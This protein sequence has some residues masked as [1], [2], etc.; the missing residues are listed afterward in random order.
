MNEL[1]KRTVFGLLYVIVIVGSI[2]LGVWAFAI[3]MLV[4]AFIGSME[5]GKLMSTEEHHSIK[6]PVAI[7]T[8]VTFAAFF[9]LAVHKEVR[10]AAVMVPFIPFIVALFVKKYSF[11]EIFLGCWVSLI[12]VFFPCVII[13][14]AATEWE[15]GLIA[16][17]GM[18]W[19][20]D[21]FAYLTGKW[22]GKH[23]LCER[24]S[25]NK[26]IEG[27]IGGLVMTAVV[28]LLVSRYLYYLLPWDIL[29]GLVLVIVV[30]G[31]LGDLCESLMKRQAGVKDSGNIIPGHGGILD[32]F[33][34]AFFAIPAAYCYLL[35]I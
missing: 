10:V 7:I 16:L 25:P 18:V 3:V 8:M 9:E 20:N 22:I 26:T 11:S 12:Y 33:D 24:I 6:I 5:V 23:K 15:D 2:L 31:T 17:F 14:L 32:R 1:T 34:A 29:L 4:T 28:A 27:S 21:I 35:L 13:M 30:F 19:V